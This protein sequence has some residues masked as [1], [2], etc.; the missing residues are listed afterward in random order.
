VDVQKV[1]SN[2]TRTSTP[3]RQQT[4]TTSPTRD[5]T[6]VVNDTP[7]VDV[8]TP[9]KTKTETVGTTDTEIKQEGELKPLS[10]EYYNQTSEDAQT[11]IINNLNMYKA[12]N[13]EY[14][15]DYDTFKRNFSYDARNNEQKNTLDVWYK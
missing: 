5:V 14:F 4:D 9:E 11:K 13:P 2:S 7:K 10:K 8:I 15:S 1:V 3:V 12:S 6:P